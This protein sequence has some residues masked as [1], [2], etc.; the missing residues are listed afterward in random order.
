MG[1]LVRY[2]DPQLLNSGS[3]A[4]FW[5]SPFVLA[6]QN[7]GVGSLPSVFN[8][9]ILIAVLSVG[10]ASVY[11]AS[12]T[13]AALA[14]N[15]Q[16]PKILG[17]IDRAGRPLVAII[18]SSSLGA[19]CYIVTLKPS[20]RQEAWNWMFAGELQ[21]SEIIQA[22]ID[23]ACVS[24]GACINFYMGIDLSLPYPFPTGLE[25]PRSHVGRIAIPLAGR[26]YR[27]LD[28]IGNQRLDPN[29]PVLDRVCTYRIQR[30]VVLGSHQ[31]L[32]RSVSRG[33]H[34]D[35][36]VHRVQAV[37]EDNHPTCQ[38]YRRR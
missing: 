30:D 29:S 6:I 37:E 3:D 13:L 25:I 17:Y 5:T 36:H 26:G 24:V 16:A 22:H 38:R 4:N 9:V 1:C 23:T 35:R 21:N 15:G 2:D 20:Q 28:R 10:N 33:A 32:L 31:E 12:R 14:D 34:C 11:G 7:A 19:L 27:F 18:V 8:A